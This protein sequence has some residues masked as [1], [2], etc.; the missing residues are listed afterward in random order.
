[1][2]FLFFI[3]LHQSLNKIGSSNHAHDEDYSTQH[4]VI[5]VGDDLHQVDGFLY[6]LRFPPPIKKN[7]TV[8]LLKVALNTTLILRGCHFPSLPEC[9]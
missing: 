3:L 8:I 6:V 5:K 2:I 4:Y 1:M 9:W 7:I